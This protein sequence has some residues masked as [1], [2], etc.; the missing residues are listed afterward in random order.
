[1][2]IP[3]STLHDTLVG[4]EYLHYILFNSIQDAE[5]RYIK[6][7]KRGI[8]YESLSCY[9]SEWRV[10]R[11]CNVRVTCIINKYT[12]SSSLRFPLKVYQALPEQR[13]FTQAI[14]PIRSPPPSPFHPSPSLPPTSCRHRHPHF[15]LSL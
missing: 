12:A 4:R 11:G 7:T 10:L 5:Q 2:Q 9:D 3:T 13:L 8:N 14:L 1:M 15:T 6:V